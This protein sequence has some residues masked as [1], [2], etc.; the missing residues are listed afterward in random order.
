MDERIRP[1]IGLRMGISHFGKGRESYGYGFLRRAIVGD[2]SPLFKVLQE[3]R[4]KS[5]LAWKVLR[6]KQGMYYPFCLLRTLLTPFLIEF[7]VG[8]TL[9][10]YLYV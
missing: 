2:D 4:R 10:L 3:K 7:G 8:K 6:R 1:K 5:K 9:I